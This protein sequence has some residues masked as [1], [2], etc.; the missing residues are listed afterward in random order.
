MATTIE[1]VLNSIKKLVENQDKGNRE[2]GQKI[3]EVVKAQKE[4]E[5]ARRKISAEVDRKIKEVL[6]AQKE[7][8]DIRRNSSGEVDRTFKELAEAQK[9]LAEAQKE[10]DKSLNKF[11]DESGFQWDELIE[12]L[13]STGT[14][15]ALKQRGI[16]VE[17]TASNVKDERR[18]QY[19][20]DVLATNTKEMVA[21]E[22]KKY[23]QKKDVDEAMKR[24]KRF[25]KH[26]KGA[27]QK[28]LYGAVAYLECKKGVNLYAERKDY[29]YFR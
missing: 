11:I 17:T 28:I 21:I 3:K 27:R 24:F 6:A 4:N 20:I 14:M 19:E 5:E 25:K 8:E 23:L 22:A 2:V 16:Q 18:H 1:D 12:T 26:Y 9:E 7:N 13:A 15:N 10:V 29:L